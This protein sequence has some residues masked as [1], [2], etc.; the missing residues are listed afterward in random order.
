MSSS[1]NGFT[2]S[3]LIPKT[4]SRRCGRQRYADPRA[5]PHLPGPLLEWRKSLLGIPIGSMLW[6]IARH[7]V[8]HWPLLNGQVREKQRALTPNE[9][10]DFARVLLEYSDVEEI[11]VEKVAN[12]I[13]ESTGQFFRITVSRDRLTHAH[14]SLIAM[15]LALRRNDWVCTHSRQSTNS[16][17]N[18]RLLLTPN[19]Q[20]N[21]A[22]LPLQV[23]R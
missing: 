16:A 22:S 21:D 7:S 12:F 18:A 14:H 11:E 8:P 19:T 10:F 23:A 20:I 17:L 1:L 13:R 6:I 15:A 2:V 9:I 4:P 3:R 5:E